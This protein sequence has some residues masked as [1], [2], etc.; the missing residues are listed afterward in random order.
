[1]E[2]VRDKVSQI[3]SLLYKGSS[4]IDVFVVHVDAHQCVKKVIA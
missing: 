4:Q 1:M 3:V 2:M